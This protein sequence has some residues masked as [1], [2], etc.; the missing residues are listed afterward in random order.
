LKKQNHL[1]KGKN[2]RKM[3]S[4]VPWTGVL[5]KKQRPFEQFADKPPISADKRQKLADKPPIPADKTKS[6]NGAPKKKK[7]ITYF[8]VIMLTM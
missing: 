4:P 3:T 8:L 1:L 5:S 6:K 2:K 7:K